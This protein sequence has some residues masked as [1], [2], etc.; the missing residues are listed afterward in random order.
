MKRLL[1]W[2]GVALLLVVLGLGG[3]VF[4]AF[5]GLSPIEDGRKLD[6]VEVVKDGIVACYLVD[7]GP[8]EVAL[9]DA[10]NDD[11][12][13]AV[14]AALSRRGLGPDAVKAILLTHGDLDHIRG[15]LAFPRA[16]VMALAADV[17]LAEGREIRMLKWLRSPKDTGVRVGRVLSDGDV[18]ELSGV[19]FR[20]HAVPGHTRGSAVYLARGV[21]FMGDSAEATT[22]GALAPAKRLTSDDPAQNRASLAKLAARLA[23]V[24][25]DVRFI[26]PAHSGVLAKGLAPLAD[27][28]LA[29]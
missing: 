27:F 19:A 26:A 1:K 14:R 4:A 23:P 29:H 25:A 28:A 24:A 13:R 9:V 18:V 10:C 6:G 3:I 20:V 22:E 15:A 5:H 11:S 7:L 17:P 12:A 8:G 21:L 2:V 16:Q